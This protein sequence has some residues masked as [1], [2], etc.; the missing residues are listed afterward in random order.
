MNK[1]NAAARAATK[2]RGISRW[3]VARLEPRTRLRLPHPRGSVTIVENDGPGF[4]KVDH[5]VVFDNEYVRVH[6]TTRVSTITTYEMPALVQITSGART[7]RTPPPRKVVS[8]KDL[9]ASST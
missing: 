2:T 7:N 8:L 6:D 3:H 5:A 9:K 1:K 4:I